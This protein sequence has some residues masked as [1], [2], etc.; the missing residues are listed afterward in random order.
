MT[1]VFMLIVVTGMLMM[2]QKLV[3]R[4][5]PDAEMPATPGTGGP[6]G[7]PDLTKLRVATQL[8]LTVVGLVGGGYVILYGDYPVQA[9]Y[10]AAG[11]VGS[12]FGFWLK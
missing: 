9:Q 4:I 8:L 5:P 10:W 12:V 1:L 7:N 6:D 2:L 3:P 11:L